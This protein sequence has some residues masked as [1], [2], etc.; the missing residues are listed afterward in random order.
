VALFLAHVSYSNTHQ[1][2][3]NN[4]KANVVSNSKKQQ[5]KAVLLT[6]IINSSYSKMG[7]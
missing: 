3:K 7:S 4:Q 2:K 1:K 6:G 5:H